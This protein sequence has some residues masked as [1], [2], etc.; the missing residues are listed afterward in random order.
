MNKYKVTVGRYCTKSKFYIQ[1]NFYSHDNL[2]KCMLLSIIKKKKTGKLRPKGLSN[3]SKAN[4]QKLESI[5]KSDGC[6]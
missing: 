4:T 6:C 3:V 2:G 5:Q 1:E